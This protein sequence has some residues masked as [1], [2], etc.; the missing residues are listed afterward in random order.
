MRRFVT[1]VLLAL[2]GVVRPATGDAQDNTL[3]EGLA[4]YEA[5]RFQEAMS[6]WRPLAETGSTEAQFYVGVLYARGEGVPADPEIAVNWY[7]RAASLGHA[8]AQFNLGV[9][10]LRGIGVATDAAEA[11]RWLEKS[12]RQAYGPAQLTFGTLLLE[13][14]GV[15]RDAAAGF[16]YVNH[17]AAQGDGRAMAVL[18]TLFR[19]GVGTTKDLDAAA[20]WLGEAARA[21]DPDAIYQ[22]AGLQALR[23]GSASASGGFEVVRKAAE[24]GLPAAQYDFG[25]ALCLGKQVTKD[26]VAC[27]G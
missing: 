1:V 24:V 22:Y 7:R 3:K 25:A 9:A 23:G 10:F 17:A 19:D 21:G 6:Q 12:A 20:R 18:G 13:G 26:E 8:K 11:A 14:R 4:A 16:G 27:A 2:A 5:G 15:A